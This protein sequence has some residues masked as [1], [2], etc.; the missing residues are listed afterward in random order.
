MAYAACQAGDWVVD[1]ECEAEKGT[2]NTA[3]AADYARCQ[4]GDWVIDTEC[5]AEKGTQNAAYA[6]QKFGCETDKKRLKGQCEALKELQKQVQV[7]AHVSGDVHASGSANLCVPG[8]AVDPNLARLGLDVSLAARGIALNGHMDYTPI[9]IPGT[10][11]GCVM[12][13]SRPLS[14]SVDIRDQRKHLTADLSSEQTD[15]GLTLKFVTGDTSIDA[16]MQPPPFEAI[17]AEHPDLAVICPVLFGV[18][19]TATLLNATTFAVSGKD[20][21]PE[22]RGQLKVPVKAATMS[23]E[24]SRQVIPIDEKLQFVGVPHVGSSTIVFSGSV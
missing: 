14:A 6:S 22:L 13:W 20:L 4:A 3:Y 11:V 23:V 8:I 5:E 16:E 1:T 24:I 10:L 2:Q 21:V 19:G 17:F 12:A 7:L 18:G 9:G 15:K